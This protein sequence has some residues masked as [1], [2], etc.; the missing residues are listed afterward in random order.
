MFCLETF[1]ALLRGGLWEHAVSLG[2][3]GPLGYD[4]LL[5]LGEEQSVLGLVTA[6]LEQVWDVPVAKADVVPLLQRV[7]A[8]ENRNSAMNE[9]VASLF[10]RLKDARIQAVLVKGQGIVQCYARPQWRAPGDVDLLLDDANYEKAKSFLSI[11][12]Q[13]VHEENPFDKH[14]TAE[15]D[16]FD[17]ELHGTMRGLLPKRAD[18]LVDA[19]QADTFAKRRT[20]NWELNGVSIPLPAPDNDVIFVFTHI[21]KHF[22]HYGVGLRQICDWCRLLWTYQD[23]IDQGVLILRLRQMQLLSEWKVFAAFAVE[24]LG[25][26]QDAM[27]FYS[28]APRW[29]RKA[30]RVK[31][32]VLKVGNFGHNRDASYQNGK[33]LVVRKAI[34]F[35]RHLGDSLRHF[36]ISPLDSL[37]VLCRLIATGLGTRTRKVGEK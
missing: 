32:F 6:G 13:V 20:R 23:S 34:S 5:R 33:S 36:F 30:C 9:F 14:F 21:L 19:V 27:P 3:Y 35:C 22:F 31:E 8:V 10:G 26:P 24:Y 15:L 17:V 12:S 4:E 28:A 2:A 29:S 25:M 37:R 18:D 11:V 7:I 1:F 16:G